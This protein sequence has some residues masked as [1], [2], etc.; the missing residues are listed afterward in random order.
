MNIMKANHFCSNYNKFVSDPG[1][2]SSVNSKSYPFGKFY[3]TAK[4]AKFQLQNS[5]GS[6]ATT[7]KF[8]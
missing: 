1:A 5:K 7:Y 8:K 4:D 6:E 3:P 2:M